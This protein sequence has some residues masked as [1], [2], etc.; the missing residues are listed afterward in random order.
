[1]TNI[2][3]S[4]SVLR[5]LIVVFI[6]GLYLPI[7]N[8]SI[9]STFI[10]EHGDMLCWLLIYL[11]HKL[12]YIIMINYIVIMIPLL[13]QELATKGDKRLR[14]IG[15]D[16][17]QQPWEILAFIFKLRCLTYCFHS[18]TWCNLLSNLFELV[19]KKLSVFCGFDWL[20][21]CSEDLKMQK[22]NA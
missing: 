4:V 16:F 15:M 7:L 20:Y 8:N 12:V 14:K 21:W 3:H 11:M 5:F 1:M 18:N 2:Y 9:R 17:V 22:S 6:V 19:G 10:K 13:L